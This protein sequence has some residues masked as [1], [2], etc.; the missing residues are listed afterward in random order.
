MSDADD[1]TSD[2]ERGTCVSFLRYG[3]L[4]VAYNITVGIAWRGRLRTTG[5][6]SESWSMERRGWVLPR[7]DA[8]TPLQCTVQRQ[9]FACKFARLVQRDIY[10]VL[11]SRYPSLKHGALHHFLPHKRKGRKPIPG[12]APGYPSI[13]ELVKRA[14]ATI[15][16]FPAQPRPVALELHWQP[17]SRTA[18]HGDLCDLA[19]PSTEIVI[20]L[21]PTPITSAEVQSADRGHPSY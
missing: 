15:V 20:N 12:S 13:A 16:C 3:G 21:L 2:W 4:I 9:R 14:D 1:R 18:L 19:I 10:H 6:F 17:R 7:V 5:H 8:R 11:L